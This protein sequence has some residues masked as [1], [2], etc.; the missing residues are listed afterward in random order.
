MSRVGIPVTFPK[1]NKDNF[2][3]DFFLKKTIHTT[4]IFTIL[5]T[6]KSYTVEGSACVSNWF[7]DQRDYT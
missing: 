7:E 1:V 5:E 4:S 2:V 3:C 6:G